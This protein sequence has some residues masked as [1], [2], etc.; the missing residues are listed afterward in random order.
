MPND[1]EVVGFTPLRGLAN[2]REIQS[3]LLTMTMTMTVPNTSPESGPVRSPLAAYGTF[4]AS[5]AKPRWRHGSQTLAF[6]NFRSQQ[7]TAKF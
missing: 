1:A 4:L 7:Y 5:E 2:H 3:I 6:S